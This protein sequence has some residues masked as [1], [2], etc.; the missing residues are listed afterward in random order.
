MYGI[1]IFA[2]TDL[3]IVICVG[4]NEYI[5]RGDRNEANGVRV[6]LCDYLYIS[7]DTGGSL[8]TSFVSR[9]QSYISQK[10]FTALAS[11]WSNYQT[12]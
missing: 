2:S 9:H 10:T 6:N 12:D 5:N 3:N 1:Y 8:S 7:V 11:A 4:Q